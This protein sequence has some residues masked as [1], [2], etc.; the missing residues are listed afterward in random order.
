MAWMTALRSG[1]A[2][3]V[4]TIRRV[5]VDRSMDGPRSTTQP[6]LTMSSARG[7]VPVVS[8]SSARYSS[9]RQSA[10]GDANGTS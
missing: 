9:E 3:D 7:S 2:F 6:A 8:R 10:R 4:R 5:A 1:M